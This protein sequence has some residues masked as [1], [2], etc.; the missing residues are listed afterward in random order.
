MASSSATPD[1]IQGMVKFR[2]MGSSMQAGAQ[3]GP[4]SSTPL[5]TRGGKAAS[6]AAHRACRVSIPTGASFGGEEAAEIRGGNDTPTKEL[7]CQRD[8]G[9]A[10]ELCEEHSTSNYSSKRQKYPLSTVIST[11]G[12]ASGAFSS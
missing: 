3:G 11:E 2:L 9:K 5:C 12:P 6:L 10:A 7:Q 4:L 8:E 1:E